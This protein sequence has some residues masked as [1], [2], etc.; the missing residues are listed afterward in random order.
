M[1][2]FVCIESWEVAN[3]VAS[4]TLTV[5]VHYQTFGIYFGTLPYTAIGAKITPLLIF[6]FSFFLLLILAPYGG[7]LPC[8]TLT[9]P[10]S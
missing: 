5:A 1:F 2:S 9:K 3:I 8:G 6:D 7:L 10:F 4:L